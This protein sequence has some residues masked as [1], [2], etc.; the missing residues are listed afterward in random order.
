MPGETYWC[1]ASGWMVYTLNS[2][3]RHLDKGSPDYDYFLA[4]YKD[5]AAGLV[6]YQGPNGGLRVWV[7]DPSA[8]EEVS[9][10][11][12]TAECF[13]EAIDKGWLGKEYEYYVSKAWKFILSSVSADGTVKNAYTGWA[14]P[15]EAGELK[16]DERE[17]G[18]VPGMVMMAA[19]RILK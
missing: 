9:S 14:I 12:M 11:A 2:L 16:M 5:I 1:R 10:T 19:A 4:V 8:P 18:F 13:R 6:K 7:D 17:L 3:L 15:A